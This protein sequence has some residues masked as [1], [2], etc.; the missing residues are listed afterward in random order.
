MHR[1]LSEQEIVRRESLQKLLELGINPYPSKLFDVNVSSTEIQTKS[2][3]FVHSKFVKLLLFPFFKS[4][5]T[6][7]LLEQFKYVKLKF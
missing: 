3:L 2:G 6:S 7:S 5:L 1:E 4:R